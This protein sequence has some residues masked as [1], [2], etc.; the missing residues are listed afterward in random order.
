MNIAIPALL[1]LLVTATTFILYR[2]HL[3]NSLFISMRE[4][5][6][7]ITNLMEYG[8]S[9]DITQWEARIAN[10]GEDTEQLEVIDAATMRFPNER[11]FIELLR[12]KLS[13]IAAG[14][15]NL[16]ARREALL[17]LRNHAERFIEHCRLDDLKYA[18][19]FRREVSQQMANVVQKIDELRKANL[20]ALVENLEQHVISLEKHSDNTDLLKR[21]EKTDQR[22]DQNI[23]SNY[24]ELRIKYDQ[25][26]GKLVQLM[27]NRSLESK[28]AI[29]AY[30]NKALGK[31]KS[32]HQFLNDS[33]KFKSRGRANGDIDSWIEDNPELEKSIRTMAKKLA[34]SD[35]GKLLPI[36]HTYIRTVESEV[37]A[38][39]PNEGK[40]LFT[41]LMIEE[42]YRE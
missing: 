41:Q 35:H 38:K 33:K 26:S 30:N 20:Q 13:P 16:L 37:F 10:M 9:N 32:A 34:V 15:E 8:H 22:I 21:I 17:R 6:N 28:A 11:P 42:S 29:K 25:I 19:D 4:Q 12:N 31:A 7:R 14:D 27:Q 5:I 39:L 2:L 36:T 1:I 24:P 23:L 18:L 40:I 3:L